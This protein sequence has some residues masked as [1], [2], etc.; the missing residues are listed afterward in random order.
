MSDLESNSKRNNFFASCNDEDDVIKAIKQQKN[1]NKK[2]EVNIRKLEDNKELDPKAKL[3][4]EKDKLKGLKLPEIKEINDE[5]IF[6]NAQDIANACDQIGSNLLPPKSS[7]KIVESPSRMI[8]SPKDINPKVL[9][10]TKFNS[11]RPQLASKFGNDEAKDA[12]PKQSPTENNQRIEETKNDEVKTESNAPSQDNK[13]SSEDDKPKRGFAFGKNKSVK[14]PT[15]GSK[16]NSPN[17][18]QLNKKG[19]P[20]IGNKKPITLKGRGIKGTNFNMHGLDSD[21][22]NDYPFDD[23]MK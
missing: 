4:A 1:Q 3:Q 19:K 17:D 9:P 10:L 5:L 15:A 8:E 7:K 14:S 16:F 6:K 20:M 21:D 23:G 11:D 2:V 22:E 12:A 13:Q 18:N